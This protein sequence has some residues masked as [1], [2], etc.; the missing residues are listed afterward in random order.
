[1]NTFSLLTLCVPRCAEN[2]LK[3]KTIY[4]YIYG[5]V[6]TNLIVLRK[7]LT[8]FITNSKFEI[9]HNF[10]SREISKHYALYYD[11]IMVVFSESPHSYRLVYD[12]SDI[13]P[14]WRFVRCPLQCVSVATVKTQNPS[15]AGRGDPVTDR[16]R[17][18]KA[19]AS[20]LVNTKAGRVNDCRNSSYSSRSLRFSPTELKS[21]GSKRK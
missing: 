17:I 6:S 12:Q 19:R 4:I 2:A 1:M 9:F 7:I 18:V 3:L 11:G 14:R 10:M 15:G 13:R 21:F 8:N 5:E 20:P 16:E